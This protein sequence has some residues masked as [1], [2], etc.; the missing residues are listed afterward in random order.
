MFQAYFYNRVAPETASLYTKPE[1]HKQAA[2]DD[3][4]AKRPDNSVVPVMAIGFTDLQTR[5]DG[6]QQ[7]IHAYRTRMHEIVDK[8]KELDDRQL[9]HT[10]PKI[11]VAMRRHTELSQRA[12]QLATKVQVLR[13]RG[14]AMRPEEE[15]LRTRL[16]ELQKR[17]KNPDTFGRTEEVWAKMTL[18]RARQKAAER[19]DSRSV[20]MINFEDGDGLDQ[21]EQVL[22]DHV[23]GLAYVA[24]VVKDDLAMVEGEIEKYRS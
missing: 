19:D 10:T 2:W 18:I 8:L 5:M 7:Q 3:A 23:K 16:T 1:N 13:C 17:L 4:V 22:E 6:Q 15:Q 24:K 14:Y 11:S 9:L 12:L 21:I 20:S